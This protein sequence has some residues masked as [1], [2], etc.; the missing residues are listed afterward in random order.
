MKVIIH[1][2]LT[3]SL[4]NFYRIGSHMLDSSCQD[5]ISL[6]LA[7]TNTQVLPSCRVASTLISTKSWETSGCSLRTRNTCSIAWRKR[8][9]AGLNHLWDYLSCIKTKNNTV[10]DCSHFPS[11]Y[12]AQL[13]LLRRQPGQYG[14]KIPP[15]SN[16]H[17]MKPNFT[18]RTIIMEM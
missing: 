15:K 2:S 11:T 16:Y 13:P 18:S 10:L 12:V 8:K 1:C 9:V 4:S 6:I 14:T 3:K 17:P 5:F 7:I